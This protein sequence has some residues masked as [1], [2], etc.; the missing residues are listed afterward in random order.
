MYDFTPFL[1]QHP[2]GSYWLEKTK[3]TD[4][5]EPFETH[6]IKG[7]SPLLLTKYKIREA[8]KPRNYVFTMNEKGFYKT[9]KR[10]VAEKLKDLDYSPIRKSNVSNLQFYLNSIL[11]LK[12]A[13]IHAYILH[14]IVI[15]LESFDLD[16]GLFLTVCTKCWGY[17]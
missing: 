11:F 10:R 6:H 16:I 1:L 12:H 4:I 8:E 13:Y 2:G 5:T 3:G 7:I 9:L 17:I 14:I 15:P